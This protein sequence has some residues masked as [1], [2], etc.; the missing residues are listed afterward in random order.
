MATEAHY[1]NM[2]I[3]SLESVT[4]TKASPRHTKRVHLYVKLY[5]VREPGHSSLCQCSG[6]HPEHRAAYE[7]HTHTHTQ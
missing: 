3:M 7:G 1:F 5:V 6:E 2:R 4:K